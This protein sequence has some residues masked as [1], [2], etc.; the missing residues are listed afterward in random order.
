MSE[1]EDPLNSED[2]EKMECRMNKKTV[3]TADLI[4]QI[5]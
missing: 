1:Y 5:K 3:H 4:E 2:Q